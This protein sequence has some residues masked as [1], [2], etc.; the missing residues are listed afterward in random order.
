[1]R[2]FLPQLCSPPLLWWSASNWAPCGLP[3]TT[4][5]WTRVPLRTS[6]CR[7]SER[8][9]DSRG[10]HPSK[11]GRA[12]SS[13]WEAA[14]LCHNRGRTSA[15]PAV[16]SLAPGRRGSSEPSLL[17]DEDAFSSPWLLLGGPVEEM[18]DISRSCY[19]HKSTTRSVKKDGDCCTRDK[20]RIAV[21]I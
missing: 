17:W 4:C 8:T 11:P 16:G 5:E 15:S 1:M 6:A 9:G 7:P 20:P 2:L 19:L 18:P 3:A 12:A 14:S 21:P 13:R 10:G